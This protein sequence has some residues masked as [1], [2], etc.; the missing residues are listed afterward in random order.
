MIGR[1]PGVI[2]ATAIGLWFCA[3]FVGAVRCLPNLP[4]GELLIAVP[5]MG[6]VGILAGAGFV[7]MVMEA[8][9]RMK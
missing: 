6:A 7:W 3:F 8:M 4:L 2:F 1:L 9:G 5:L